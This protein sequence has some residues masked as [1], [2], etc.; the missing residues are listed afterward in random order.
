[1]C[2]LSA[3]VI[4]Y[5]SIVVSYYVAINASS[6]AIQ[7]EKRQLSRYA[8][9]REIERVNLLLLKREAEAEFATE[10][11]GAI[12]TRINM[13]NLVELKPLMEKLNELAAEEMRLAHFVTG[14]GY[15]NEFGIVVPARPPI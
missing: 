3:P 2:N 5:V 15:T 7:Q 11:A 4:L 6:L 13:M 8:K 1:V 12:Q 9:R 10:E 14:Q